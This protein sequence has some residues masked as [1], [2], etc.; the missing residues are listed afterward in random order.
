MA[1]TMAL[2]VHA[3]C[4]PGHH[5][6]QT[7]WPDAIP[8]DGERQTPMPSTIRTLFM[9]FGAIW[10]AAWPMF[11]QSQWQAISFGLS[12]ISPIRS[13]RNIE[14]PLFPIHSL[15]PAANSDRNTPAC[16]FSRMVNR[17]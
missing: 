4:R 13:V 16:P 6:T 5:Q 7:L 3:Q 17:H 1:F 12:H 10:V 2:F 11:R 8:V 9:R 15:P 14:E